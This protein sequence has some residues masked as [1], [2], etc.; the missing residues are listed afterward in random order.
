[1][2]SRRLRA[3]PRGGTPSTEA[4]GRSFRWE[5][6]VSLLDHALAL[7]AKGCPVFPLELASKKPLIRGWPGL[8]TNDADL[9]RAWWARW[10]DANVGIH[11][12]GLLVVDVDGP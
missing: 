12:R 4:G 2:D 8:A 11:C 10:P 9:I 6:P 5:A 3:A 7:A 1:M